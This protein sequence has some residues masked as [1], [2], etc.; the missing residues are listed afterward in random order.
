MYWFV[1]SV[2]YVKYLDDL[3]L[4]LQQLY[5]ENEYATTSTLL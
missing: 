4:G 3:T 1:F 5:A 2:H